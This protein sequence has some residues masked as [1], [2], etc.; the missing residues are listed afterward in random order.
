MIRN[1]TGLVKDNYALW[2]VIIIMGLSGIMAQVIIL[3]EL[4]IVSFGNELIIGIVLSSWLLFEAAGSWL[5][6]KFK[7][8]DRNTINLLILFQVI[9]AVILPV[10]ISIARLSKN[11]AGIP[12]AGGLGLLSIILLSFIILLPV[13]F[14]HGALFT[15][16]CRVALSIIKKNTVSISRVYIIELI[17]TMIGGFLVYLTIILKIP[18]L[19]TAF[20]LSLTNVI[21]LIPWY[22]MISKASKTISCNYNNNLQD[23]IKLTHEKFYHKSF[24]YVLT[25]IAVIFITMYLS[26]FVTKINKHTLEYQW[27]GHNLLHY[28]NSIYGN[29]V[30]TYSNGQYSF[31]SDGQP[32]IISPHSDIYFSEMIVHP[33]MASHRKPENILVIGAGAGGILT[34][35]L[36]YPVKQVDYTELDHLLIELIRKYPTDIIEKEL[37]H[38]AVSIVNMDGRRFV[39]KTNDLYDVVIIGFDSSYDLQTNRLFTVEFLK[40]LSTRMTDDAILSLI[41]PG[42]IS[43]LTNEVRHINQITENSLTSV[44]NNVKI[45][46]DDNNLFL[47]TKSKQK[48]FF[49]PERIIEQMANKGITTSMISPNYLNHLFQNYRKEWY[50][51]QIGDISTAVNTDLYPLLLFYNI[52]YWNSKVAPL[53]HKFFQN[54]AHLNYKLIVFIMAVITVILLLLIMCM[55]YNSLKI[56]MP[57]TIITSGFSGM[58]FDLSL[59]YLFQIYFGYVFAWIGMLFVAYMMG[60]AGGAL[61]SKRII[62]YNK[63]ADMNTHREDPALLE[64]K[65]LSKTPTKYYNSLLSYDLYIVLF[66][67]IIIITANYIRPILTLHPLFFLIFPFSGGYIIGAQFPLAVEGYFRTTGNFNNSASILYS[68]DLVGGFLGGITGG[69]VLLPFFGL[70]NTMYFVLAVKAFSLI[71]LSLGKKY[72]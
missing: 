47:A 40:T 36:K 62:N 31:F 12:A 53:S 24:I 2:A 38:P 50:R 18:A 59:I 44:F 25:I 41:K 30:V 5:S 37:T 34:E 7:S 56:T 9:F 19:Y 22:L 1:F 14:L 11:I 60:A 66:T 26:G 57:L 58:I 43:Y 3:R 64:G 71:A 29:L 45:V 46:P 48:E 13:S 27:S 20:G 23:S 52:S 67:L 33:A 68:A 28:Q 63:K 49:N 70:T 35:I 21:I 4:L 8:K 6:G 65:Y 55:K 16:N 17:G 61:R 10:S 51:E 72:S 54:I 39:E 32:V 42:S 69:I 15:L